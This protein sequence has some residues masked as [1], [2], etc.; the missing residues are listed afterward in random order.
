MDPTGVYV[1]GFYDEGGMRVFMK[2]H[3]LTYIHTY[4]HTHTH[5]QYQSGRTTPLPFKKGVILMGETTRLHCCS[6]CLC[7]WVCEWWC[8]TVQRACPLQF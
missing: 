2:W 7:V 5:T 8:D 1:Y 4:I 6:V 3:T